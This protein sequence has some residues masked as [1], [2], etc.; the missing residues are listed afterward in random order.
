M[1]HYNAHFYTLRDA[2][3]TKIGST[4]IIRNIHRDHAFYGPDFVIQKKRLEKQECQK[5]LFPGRSKDKERW[6]INLNK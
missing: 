2:P 5:F 4:K 6:I 3:K 1:K